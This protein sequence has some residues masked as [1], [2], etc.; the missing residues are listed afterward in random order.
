MLFVTASWAA[1][2]IHPR[3]A[4]CDDF[5]WPR[6]TRD[7]QNRMVDSTIWDAFVFRDD[8]IVVASWAKSGTTWT[9]QLVGQLLTDG[10]ANFDH[11]KVSPW[12][13][14]RTPPREQMLEMLEAQEFRRC[15]K[16]HLSID[17]LVFSPKAKYLYLARDGRDVVWSYYNHHKSMLPLAYEMFNVPEFPGPLLEPPKDDIREYW[18]DW[19]DHDGYPLWPFWSHVRGWWNIRHLPNVK[20]LHFANLKRDFEGEARGVAEFLG[21][22]INEDRWA[23]ILEHCSLE[24]MRKQDKAKGFFVPGSFFYKGTNGRWKDTLT[25][26]E[27]EEYESR[28][29]AELGEECAHW[30]ATGQVLG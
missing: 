2:R 20:L 14:L 4:M 19:M 9:Q 30:L 11:D 3:K 23:D 29:V 25:E 1:S 12:V 5:E 13:D 10:D 18:R 26:A 24:W 16:T 8:D 27:S 17:A 22:P 15:L 6:K 7:E 21:I 28:A